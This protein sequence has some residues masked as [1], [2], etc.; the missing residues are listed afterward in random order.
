MTHLKKI[1]MELSGQISKCWLNIIFLEI[2]NDDQWGKIFG[3][4]RFSGS[5][6]DAQQCDDRSVIYYNNT[7]HQIR[8]E[9]LFVTIYQ[10]WK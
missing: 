3:L 7:I 1:H 2:E 6:S 8:I 5:V 10:K 9:I 4:L